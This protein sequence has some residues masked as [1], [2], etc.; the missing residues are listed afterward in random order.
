MNHHLH[1]SE[2]TNPSTFYEA[3]LEA[4]RKFDV[5]N[6]NYEQLSDLCQKVGNVKIGL[7]KDAI[8]RIPTRTLY[9]SDLTEKPQ[10]QEKQQP[11]PLPTGKTISQQPNQYQQKVNSVFS[12]SSALQQQQV[13]FP[14]YEDG[15]TAIRNQ[16]LLMRRPPPSTQQENNDNNNISK[17]STTPPTTSSTSS[18]SILLPKQNLVKEACCICMSDLLEE[19]EKMSRIK[20][21]P[22]KH[23]FHAKCIKTWLE[24]SKKCP[25]CKT[26]VARQSASVGALFCQL[27]G[28]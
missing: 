13:H 5:E 28:K 12:S 7:T 9:R 27:M 14:K 22:C 18:S 6:M 15:S 4:A 1:P 23:T 8:S 19:N 10:Q 16:R 25:V 11:P 24:N 20:T 17:A 21:L 26:D 3:E 2:I